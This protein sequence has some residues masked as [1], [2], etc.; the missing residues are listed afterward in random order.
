VKA[1][2]APAARFG[3]LTAV[4]LGRG[5]DPGP[6]GRS[7]EGAAVLRERAA[8][9]RRALVEGIRDAAA[10]AAAPGQRRRRRAAG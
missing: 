10:R 3:V 5:E 7:A 1:D 8:A 2:S 6:D 4:R 9:V